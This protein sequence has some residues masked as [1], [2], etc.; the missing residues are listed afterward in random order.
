[1]KAVDHSEAV[2]KFIV[3]A[4]AYCAIVEQAA[5]VAP[6]LLAE[7]F[8]IALADLYSHALRLPELAPCEESTLIE[9]GEV[10]PAVQQALARLGFSSSE[11]TAEDEYLNSLSLT[12][13]LADIYGELKGALDFYESSDSCVQAN[14]VWEIKFGFEV[15]WRE[16]L[17]HALY[18]LDRVLRENTLPEEL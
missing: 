10:P 5:G 11:N 2:S 1:M 18:V 14:A 9:R 6:H 15:H 16:H 13:D 4:R 12:D 3:S 17:V 8:A 7:E